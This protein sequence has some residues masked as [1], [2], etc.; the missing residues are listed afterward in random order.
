[1]R[2]KRVRQKQVSKLSRVI[3]QV[4]G[5]DRFD[6]RQMYLRIQRL[7]FNKLLVN[8]IGYEYIWIK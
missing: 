1:M 4:S 3:P 6:P 5:R 2:N 8:K 7:S